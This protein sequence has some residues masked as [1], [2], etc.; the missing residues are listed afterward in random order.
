MTL[1]LREASNEKINKIKPLDV[2]IP[3]IPG[4]PLVGNIWW[5]LT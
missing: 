1:R 3:P 4:C 5:G 2:C